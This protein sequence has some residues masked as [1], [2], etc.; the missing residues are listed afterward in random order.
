M[1]VEQQYADS[2]GQTE[3]AFAF[4]RLLGFELMPRL[5]NIHN[6]KLYRPEAGSSDAYLNPQAVLTRS[7]NWE[8]V[9]QEFDAMVKHRIPL[10]DIITSP[11]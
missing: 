8:L 11:S 10:G 2:H 9:E 6:Q 3:V 1:K 7:I 4:C 5:K